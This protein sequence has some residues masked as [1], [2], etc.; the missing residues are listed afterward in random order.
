ML[1]F[2]L[3]GATL[4]YAG[5]CELIKSVLQGVECF[6]LSILPFPKGVK[7]KVIS[8]C[9]NFLWG[10]K[11]TS[12]KHPL[13]A[14][15]EICRPKSEG[16]LGFIDLNACNSALLSKF[17]WNLQTKNDSLWVKWI[18]QIYLKWSSFGEYVSTKQD[19]QIIK[20]LILIRDQIV[21]EEGNSPAALL[22]MHQWTTLA[23]FKSKACYDFF[24]PKGFAVCWAKLVWHHSLLPKHAFILWLSLKERLL[25]RDKLI[26][27]IEDS[28]CILCGAPIESVNH[29]FFHCSGV[30]QIWA[31][32]K[33]WL[34]FSRALSTLKAAAKWIKKEGRGTGAQAIAKKVGLACTVYSIWTMRNARMFEGKIISPAD[35]IRDIKIQV[36][37][38]LYATFS[39]IREM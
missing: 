14:W 7:D 33:G 11:A 12:Y 30:N 23:R 10:G 16:G 1:Y 25:T 27:Q 29:L 15:R 38:V 6:W 39:N 2:C 37:R 35:A 36:Y 28:S 9:R 31:A 22:K 20:Q 18:H 24:R 8:L 13:V 5:R 26:D 19:S 3:A 21:L 17:I 4:S 34:G 32:I